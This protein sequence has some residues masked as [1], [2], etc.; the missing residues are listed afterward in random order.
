MVLLILM[1]SEL[2]QCLK[3]VLS[4][5]LLT[6]ENSPLHKFILFMTLSLLLF[7]SEVLMFS[8]FMNIVVILKLI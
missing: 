5:K 2:Y 8:E 1:I 7:A 4:V 6:M 3:S